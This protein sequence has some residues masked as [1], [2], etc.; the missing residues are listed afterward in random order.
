[1]IVGGEVMAHS[2]LQR[3]F[4]LILET[5]LN[6]KAQGL[7]E[8]GLIIILIAIAIITVLGLLGVQVN[9]LYEN[10]INSF[11]ES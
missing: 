11:P 6:K 9:T 7:I 3:I 1:V 5:E 8:Y 4:L 10:V 2:L